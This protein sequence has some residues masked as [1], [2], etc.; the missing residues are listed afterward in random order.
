MVSQSNITAIK[1]SGREFD[2]L[3]P[4]QDLSVR[5]AKLRELPTLARIARETIPGIS[6]SGTQLKAFWGRDRDTVF[7]F[8][9]GARL[10]GGVAFLY[11]NPLGLDA[12]VLDDIN[13]ANPE[14]KFLAAP[15]EQPEAI[16]LWAISGAGMKALG[17]VAP[18]FAEGR[19]RTADIYTRPVTRDGELLMTRMGFEPSQSWRAGLWKYERIVN[20]AGEPPAI[21]NAA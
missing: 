18:R 2:L 12:L 5:P 9:R 15:D 14:L 11:L 13:L 4:A 10:I 20:K 3:I 21:K 19:Y 8:S 7:S 6:L 16:Y 17:H 1:S